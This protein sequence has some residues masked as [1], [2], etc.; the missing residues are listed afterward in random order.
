MK[1]M[2]SLMIAATAVAVSFA[3]GRGTADRTPQLHQPTIDNLMTAAHSEAFAYAKYMLYAQHARQSGRP[4]LAD[5]FER[6]AAMERFE[7][8]KDEAELVGLVGRNADNLQE[9]LKGETYEADTMYR[10]FARQAAAVGDKLA[11]DRFEKIR[12]DEMEHRD[13]FRTA[14]ARIQSSDR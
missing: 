5:L 1:I 3:I 7:H 12:E 14:M 8:F 6:A 4:D 2:I 11:A 9:A 10:N 13:A